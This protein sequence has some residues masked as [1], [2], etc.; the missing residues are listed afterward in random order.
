MG[1]ETF[2]TRYH[3]IIG[4]RRALR[5]KGY[6]TYADVGLDGDWVSP[7]QIASGSPT[8]PVLL[9]YN[10]LDAPTAQTHR[11]VLRAHGFLPAMLFN[12]VLD[13]ALA[14]S[15]LTR[16]S[17]YVTHAFHLLPASRSAAVPRWAIDLS[18]EAVAKHELE[19]RNVIALGEVAGAACLRHGV[20]HRSVPH[21]SAR[22][23]SHMRKAALLA[24]ALAP[25]GCLPRAKPRLDVLSSALR[26][27]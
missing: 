25:Y 16:C 26:S 3:A 10:F 23:L 8:G 5:L 1:P 22:G 15:G 9:T 14:M 11:D 20:A 27:A 24:E 21:L 17:L 7:Y 4:L 12:R 6:Q 2:A 13:L 19:G 18:F